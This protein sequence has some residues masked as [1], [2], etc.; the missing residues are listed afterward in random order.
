MNEYKY[1][2]RGVSASKDE[3]HNAISSMDKGLYPGA[4]CKVLP[5]I[6]CGDG[7]YVNIMHADTA[8]TKTALAYIYWKETGNLDVWYDIV[9]DAIVMN[10]DDMACTGV[11]G[12]ILLSS[13]IGRNKHLIPGEVIERL[14]RAPEI[15]INKMKE[16]GIA[17]YLSGGETADAGDIVRTVDVGITA[18]AR[19]PKD[20]LIVND[21][22][23]KDVIVGLASFGKAE[24]EEYYNSGIGSNGLTSARHD[25][26]AAIY[27]DKYPES[28]SP[29]TEREYVYSGKR[30]LTGKID[31]GDG[32]MDLGR[33]VLS[34]TRTY[35][36]VLKAVF[37]KHRKNINGIIHCTG[38][39]QTKV[40]KFV[41][42]KK[43]IKD[44]LFPVPHIFDLIQRESRTPWKEMY[45][46]FNMGHRLEIYLPEAYAGDIISIAKSFGVDAR[47]VGRVEEAPHNQ[48]VIK[49]PAGEVVY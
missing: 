35:L 1:E 42:N 45:R 17:I 27:R 20:K 8:G 40:M 23:D 5:D 38:G 9:Q 16:Y 43:I 33:F 29:E 2:K 31:T 18:F 12:N 15:F 47:V 19:L 39:G 14:I 41:K 36:P 4:F 26:F 30:L 21:I 34:P 11:T 49:S 24:Y 13:T 22:R 46:V 6:A 44:N 48:L 3:I 32:I 25:I 37:K 28:Y 10:V 7:K